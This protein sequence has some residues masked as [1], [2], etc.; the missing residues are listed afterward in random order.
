MILLNKIFSCQVI[1]SLGV[2]ELRTKVSGCTGKIQ[3]VCQ[4]GNLNCFV[5]SRIDVMVW[6]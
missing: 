6:I 4:I 5:S 2:E 1:P 3:Y